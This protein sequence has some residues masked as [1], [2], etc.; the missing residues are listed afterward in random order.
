MDEE[1]GEKLKRKADLICILI[2]CPQVPDSTIEGERKLL[3]QWCRK[4]LPQSM[5][6]YDMVY[7]ARF[8]RLIQQFRAG[9]KSA[10]TV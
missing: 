2:F 7:E 4:F 10:P 6:L 5:D 1:L 8:N 3:R 9:L